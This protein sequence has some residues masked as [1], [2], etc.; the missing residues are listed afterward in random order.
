MAKMHTHKANGA[1]FSVKPLLLFCFVLS[2]WKSSLIYIIFW[3]PMQY[4]WSHI[5]PTHCTWTC[6]LSSMSFM[7][8]TWHFHWGN[9]CIRFILEKSCTSCCFSSSSVWLFKHATHP[10]YTAFLLRHLHPVYFKKQVYFLL[11]HPGNLHVMSKGVFKSLFNKISLKH[12]SIYCCWLLPS[13]I[14]SL[15]QIQKIYL[16]PPMSRIW[17]KV[18]F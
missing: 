1:G 2:G 9:T 13:K 11:S 18:N 7:Q 3:T 17:L 4:S 10:I 8:F 5:S 12:Y 16:P 15:A 6:L 14:Q